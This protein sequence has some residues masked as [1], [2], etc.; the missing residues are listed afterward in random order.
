MS[1]MKKIV[2]IILFVIVI[3]LSGCIGTEQKHVTNITD[4]VIQK[5]PIKIIDKSVL[6]NDVDDVNIDNQ[7]WDETEENGAI[8]DNQGID[9]Y[10][11]DNIDIDEEISTDPDS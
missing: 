3:L 8:I 7:S 5:D 11:G 9:E 10:G 1:N 2:L 4:V 6:G